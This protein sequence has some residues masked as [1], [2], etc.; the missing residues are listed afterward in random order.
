MLRYRR[1]PFRERRKHSNMEHDNSKA[2]LATT[3]GQGENARGHRAGIRAKNPFGVRL[4][5]D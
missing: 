5:K 4:F 3:T 1:S 2:T